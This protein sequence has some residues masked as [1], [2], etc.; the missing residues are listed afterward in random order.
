MWFSVEKID[1]GDKMK[2]TDIVINWLKEN[3]Y[4]GLVNIDLKTEGKARVRA[5]AKEANIAHIVIH[6][7]I[8]I[9]HV[10]VQNHLT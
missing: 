6:I 3:R 4:D 5:R 9:C 8:H 7:I 2:V 1:I 10:R